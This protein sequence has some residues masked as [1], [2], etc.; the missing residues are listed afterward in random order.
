MKEMVSL[1]ER[2]VHT[3]SLTWG[4]SHFDADLLLPP[5]GFW[6][7]QFLSVFLVGKLTSLSEET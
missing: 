7:F 2:Y 6:C 1:N 3:I 5:A 4:N